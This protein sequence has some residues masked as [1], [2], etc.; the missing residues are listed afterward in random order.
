MSEILISCIIPASKKDAESQ[1]LKDLIASIKTQDFP[2]DQIEIIVV[3]NVGQDGMTLLNNSQEGVL[4]INDDS[5][6]EQAKALGIREAKGEIVDNEVVRKQSQKRP[7]LC[8][9]II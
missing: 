8:L 3:T 4:Y 5:D 1:N 6:S 9:K 2:Q 7:P